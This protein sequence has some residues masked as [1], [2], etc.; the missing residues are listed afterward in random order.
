MFVTYE[1]TTDDGKSFTINANW[2]EWDDWNVQPE[3]ITWDGEEGTEEQIKEII[4]L[5]ENEMNN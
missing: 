2:N 5:F 4:T 3:E 1:G